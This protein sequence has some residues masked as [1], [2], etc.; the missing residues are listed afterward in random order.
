MLAGSFIVLCAATSWAGPV[1]IT[2]EPSGSM[3][4][5][6]FSLIHAATNEM[7][8]SGYYTGG[9]HLYN[10]ISGFLLGD[11]SGTPGNN[12]TLSNILG[13]L[14][15]D[16]V[17]MPGSEATLNITSGSFLAEQQDGLV[18]GELNYSLTGVPSPV[19]GTFYFDAIDFLSNPGPNRLSEISFV[20]W[21]NNWDK[22]GGASRPDPGALGIDLKANI[23]AVPE[24]STVLL[25]GTGFAALI[26]WR[27]RKSQR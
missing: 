24:P 17:G 12:L 14:T 4:G 2:I 7:G 13:S 22:E 11:L 9:N 26:G 16:I 19:S 5:F 27:Y 25:I 8:T 18:D 15:M 20:L 6:G 3:G 21:A 1:K 10:N 23:D